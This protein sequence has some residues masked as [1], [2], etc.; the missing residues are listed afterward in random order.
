ME[1]PMAKV[2]RK[3]NL[4]VLGYVYDR[5]FILHVHCNKLVAYLRSMLG[6]VH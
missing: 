5:L 1:Q 6:V 3:V 4:V 2:D